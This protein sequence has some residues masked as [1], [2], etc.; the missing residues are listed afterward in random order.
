MKTVSLSLMAIALLTACSNG[1][2]LTWEDNPVSVHRFYADN[3]QDHPFDTGPITVLSEEHG[4]LKS[5]TLRTCGEDHVCGSRKG[6]VTRAPDYWV[7]K[8]AYAGRVFYISAGGDGWVKHGSEL[9]PIAW[10]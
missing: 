10:N 1:Q 6:H 2:G 9:I 7:V 5:Y 3:F 8:G 4:D